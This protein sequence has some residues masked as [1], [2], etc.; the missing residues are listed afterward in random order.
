MI[1]RLKKAHLKLSLEQDK[2][3]TVPGK[4]FEE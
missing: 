2:I 1:R 4:R 3:K